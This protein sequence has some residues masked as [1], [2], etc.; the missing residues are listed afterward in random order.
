M[1]KAD[2]DIPLNRK[3]MNRIIRYKGSKYLTF[4]CKLQH[5]M[6]ASRL[7]PFLFAE[8]QNQRNHRRNTILFCERR[9][10][11]FYSKPF[12]V[13]L[14]YPS[15]LPAVICRIKFHD[16]ERFAVINLRLVFQ[17]QQ[18]ELHLTFIE[19]VNHI[20]YMLVLCRIFRYRLY[21]ALLLQE[22]R[23]NH[24]F[25]LIQPGTPFPVPGQTEIRIDKR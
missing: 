2:V 12:S 3:H 1:Q 7:F 21:R 6:Q 9:E 10:S 23:A 25:P 8:I 17:S 19:H 5:I 15:D 13:L 16:T 11:C 20:S 18:K 24:L 22:I 4:L 14:F